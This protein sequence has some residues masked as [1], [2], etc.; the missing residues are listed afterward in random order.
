MTSNKYL[1]TIGLYSLSFVLIMVTVYAITQVVQI[2][3]EHLNSTT[4]VIVLVLAIT[5]I[6][7]LSILSAERKGKFLWVLIICGAIFGGAFPWVY[8]PAANSDFFSK[9]PGEIW[10]GAA[11]YTPPSMIIGITI[12]L[13]THRVASKKPK[14]N[15][16]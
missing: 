13:I 8:L 16:L 12:S 9:Y 4:L 10:L 1:Y 15:K 14:E 7:I 11:F 2:Y 5:T 6:V 3:K